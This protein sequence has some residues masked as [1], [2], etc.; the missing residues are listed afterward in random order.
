MNLNHREISMSEL[1]NVIYPQRERYYYALCLQSMTER[2][3]SHVSKM[4][5]SYNSKT[6]D[7]DLELPG[8]T[9]LEI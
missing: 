5:T 2:K 6:T 3:N 4:Y 7:I 8:K 1:R 9:N